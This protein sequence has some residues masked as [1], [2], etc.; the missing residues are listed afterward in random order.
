MKDEPIFIEKVQKLKSFLEKDPSG[1]KFFLKLCSVPLFDWNLF[2]KVAGREDRGTDF[3]LIADTFETVGS[4]SGKPDEKKCHLL[5]VGERYRQMAIGLST[6]EE[7][8]QGLV[9]LTEDMLKVCS[10]IVDS[11]S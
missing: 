11:F 8:L 10:E 6:S 5:K 1:R 9:A 7:R 2:S 3:S 4:L